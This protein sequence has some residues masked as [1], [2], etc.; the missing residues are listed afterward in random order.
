VF[1]YRGRKDTTVNRPAATDEGLFFDTTRNALQRSNGTTYDD[2]ATM[3]PAGT[4]MVFYQASAPVGWTAVAANDKFLRV[5]TAGGTGGTTGGTVAASTSLAHTHLMQDDTLLTDMTLDQH[6]VGNYGDSING[7]GVRAVTTGGGTY[8]FR[9]MKSIT[10]SKLG[11][12]AY[13]DIIICT[14]D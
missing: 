7:D 6:G 11:A 9:T 2:V 12:L 3:L 14:K 1:A 10:D 8:H 5:V 13:A 4:A